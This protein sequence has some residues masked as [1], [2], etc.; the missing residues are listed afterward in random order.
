MYYTTCPY[1]GAHL[2]PGE[3]CDCREEKT[4]KVSRREE[5]RKEPVNYVEERNGQLRIAVRGRRS[6]EEFQH[7]YMDCSDRCALCFD[8]PLRRK[9]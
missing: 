6:D 1:C 2:D 9:K 7:R 4:A 8:R 5:I 3:K